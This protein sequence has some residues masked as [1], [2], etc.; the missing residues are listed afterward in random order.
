MPYPLYQQIKRIAERREC[1]VSEVFRRAVEEYVAGAPRFPRGRIIDA[2]PA[3]TLRA[4]HRSYAALHT[5]TASSSR[6]WGSLSPT[7]G[8]AA[9]G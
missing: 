2:C 7:P 1:S 4:A 8:L 3:L 9:D 5:G 6:S